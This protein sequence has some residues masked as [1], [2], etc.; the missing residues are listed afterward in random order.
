MYPTD[1]F[2]SLSIVNIG[3]SLNI[4]EFEKENI[5][6]VHAESFLFIFN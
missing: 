2:Y 3:A 4:I 1:Y 6:W 5:N